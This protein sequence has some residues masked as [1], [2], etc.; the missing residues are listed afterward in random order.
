VRPG[1]SL[2]SL[3]A[4]Y[5]TTADAIRQANGLQSNVIYV[6]QVLAIPVRR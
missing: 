6:G 2:Y 5:R 3:A 4:R 1:E